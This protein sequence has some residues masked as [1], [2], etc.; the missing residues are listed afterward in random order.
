MKKVYLLVSA[1]TLGF[2]SFGQINRTFMNETQQNRLSKANESIK[3][4][5]TQAPVEKAAGDVLFGETFTGSAGS[6]TTSGVN[7]ALWLYDIDGPNG[8][9]SATTQKI[10]SPT[11]TTGFMIVDS[12]LFNVGGTSNDVD[13][14]LVS[15]VIDLSAAPGAVINFYSR[16]RS[17]CSNSFYPKIE[18]STD[19]F[20]SDI[21]E[22]DVTVPGVAV[23]DDSDSKLVSVNISSY[24]AT[25]INKTNF[26]FRF[27]WTAASHYFWMVDDIAIVEAASNDISLSQVFL[28]DIST[29]YEHTEIP[30]TFAGALTV[31]GY[32]SNKGYSPIPTSTQMI[33]TVFDGTGTQIATETGGVLS[34]S[35]STT[36]DTITFAT[37]IDLSTYTI[38]TYSLRADLVTTEIDADF[39]NDSL[40]RTLKITD[41]YLGQRDYEAART[42]ESAGT[43]YGTAPNADP[44][45]FG[46]S[47]SIPVDVSC[48]GLEVTLGRT[49]NLPITTADNQIEIKLFERDYTAADYNSSFVDLG[50]SRFFTLKSTDVPA[51]NAFKDVLFNFSD[52]TGATG[53]FV[54]TGGKDYVIA[55]YHNGGTTKMAYGVNIGDQDNSSH[56]YGAFSS[57]PGDFWFSN[58]T[59]ILTRMNFNPQ[60]AIDAGVKELTNNANLSVYPNPATSQTNVSFSLKN[61]TEVVV[62]LTDLTGKTVF[63]NNLG[64]LTTGAHKTTIN[65]DVLSN[66]VYMVNFV[67]NGVVSTQK[68][69]VR[70]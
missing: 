63:T 69:I 52:A 35:L 70:K 1:I 8:E 9:Y 5:K 10:V 57:S 54:L 42:I 2:G 59:Q 51:L 46:N 26:K 44:M 3:S 20:V 11:S 40:R 18:V 62:S 55:V 50:E 17:C 30:T 27:V 64:T 6:W 41:F 67:A 23:N 28:N 14:S 56:V 65:T 58:G 7:A 45:M 34:N 43:S 68:L 48:H 15:P 31:Q 66:G 19:D 25:A 53:P 49:T 39:T 47:M 32:I 21:V 29:G 33:V 37:S 13:A 61:D 38:G 36:V 16:Y 60:L 24:L 22:F 4:D 12:D